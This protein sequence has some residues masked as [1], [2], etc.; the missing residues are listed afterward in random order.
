MAFT[1]LNT[2][3]RKD[4]RDFSQRPLIGIFPIHARHAGTCCA[5]NHHLAGSE[6]R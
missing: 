5:E 4:L 3:L 1:T 2:F 6:H